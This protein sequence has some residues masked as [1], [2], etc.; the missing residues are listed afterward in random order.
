VRADLINARYELQVAAAAI[1]RL[2]AA[3]PK[4]LAK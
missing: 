2:R 3:Y 1:D 4:D